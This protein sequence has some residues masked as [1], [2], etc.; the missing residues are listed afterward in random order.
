MTPGFVFKRVTRLMLCITVFFTSVA[1]AQ[2][3]TGGLALYTVREDM[4]KNPVETLEKVAQTGYSY[5]EA[6]GYQNGKFYGMVPSAFNSQLKKLGLQPISTH[7][8][9]VTLENADAM[10][11]DVKA[12]GFKYFVVPVP[13]MGMFKYNRETNKM[14]MEGT[15][16]DLADILETLGK[17]CHEAGLELLYHNH[18]F[19]FMP[20][21][22]GV[23]PIDYLLENLD[24]EYVNFQMDLFWVTK[25][26]A[27]PLAYF[28][29]YPGRFKIWHV[30]D[31]DDQGRFAPVGKGTIDFS[32]IL[33]K[34]E[35]SGMKYFMVEQDRTF[36][37]LKPLEAIKIS[38]ESI[39]KIGF[40]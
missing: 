35:L 5:I 8:G 3:K 26:G 7:Q 36:D 6:A 11:A 1:S 14:G 39:K 23:V 9:S 38:Q 4:R 15:V 40:K 16:G 28:E 17:K 21:E 32:R 30:K 18:D 34:K 20:D 27:D 22:N 24:P 13:P 37:G 2:E 33:E 10:I 25:A 12:A 29:K 31:M 19:E